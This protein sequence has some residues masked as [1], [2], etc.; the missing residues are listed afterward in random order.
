MK[1]TVVV[2]IVLCIV[3]TSVFARGASEEASGKVIELGWYQPEPDSHAWTETAYLIADEIEKNSNGSIKIT[4]YP[5][6]VL[7]TQAEAVDMLRTGSL[8]LLTSGPS[9]LASFY[10]PVQVFSLPFAF[11]N[12]AQG[13]AFFE[14][15]AGQSIFNLIEE[16]SGVKTLDVWYFGDRNLTINGINVTK[17]KDLEGVPCRCMDTPVA[18]TVMRSLGGSPVPLNIS[19]LYLSLQTG[20]VK[21]QEN[22]IPTIIAQKFYEVQDTIVLTRHSV[23]L[24]TV[25]VSSGIW[26]TLSSE[27]QKVIIDALAKY[28][29]IIEQKINRQTEVGLTFLK[30]QGMRVVE[31]DLGPFKENAAKVIAET[32]GSNPEWMR[33]IN[34][35][36]EFK[37]NY[38][39]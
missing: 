25:H 29:P 8:A 2:L 18:K 4:I 30:E 15:E 23:H 17:P 11:D 31:P 12:A 32:F 1:K 9:I 24:G 3:L 20:V 35:L 26:N 5:A 38:K 37:A 34:A 39:K 10:D 19:E 21:G 27:Q 36:N 13:Y 33:Q 28:R 16:K 22:P 6:S 7:G 14:S